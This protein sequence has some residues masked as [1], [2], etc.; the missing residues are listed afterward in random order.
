MLHFPGILEKQANM[1]AVT[2][3]ES[4]WPA[5]QDIYVLDMNTSYILFF[6]GMIEEGGTDSDG[7]G[8]NIL[9]VYNARFALPKIATSRSAL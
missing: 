1:P 4:I 9:V 3:P 7:Q 8:Y 5:V 2:N 6:N